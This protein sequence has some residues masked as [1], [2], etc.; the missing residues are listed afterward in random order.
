MGGLTGIFL[1][2]GIGPSLVAP[3]D[4]D[5]SDN[6]Q[7][8]VQQLKAAT[9]QAQTSSESSSESGRLRR[10]DDPLAGIRQASILA[11][12]VAALVGI[13]ATTVAQRVGHIPTPRG[14]GL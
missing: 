8:D 4:Q 12:F 3:L 9:F 2:W 13:V 5:G 1:G 11:T 7:I 14:L 6:P 10:K